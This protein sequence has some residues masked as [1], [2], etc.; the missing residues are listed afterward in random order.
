MNKPLCG[1]SSTRWKCHI[2]IWRL[3]LRYLVWPKNN[4]RISTSRSGSLILKPKPL[5]SQDRM[6]SRPLASTK[7]SISWSFPG[8]CFSDPVFLL[9]VF[10]II[11]FVDVDVGDGVGRHI[12]EKYS[13]CFGFGF[14]FDFMSEV[15]CELTWSLEHHRSSSES[16]QAYFS[17]KGTWQKHPK[18]CWHWVF[19][20]ANGK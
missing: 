10:L 7:L 12:I 5:R 16:V 9:L 2:F 1:P 14:G 19:A 8:N 3:K 15:F 20:H 6:Y 13:V 17:E 4:G 11:L 18:D